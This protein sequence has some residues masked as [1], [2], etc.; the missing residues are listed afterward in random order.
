MERPHLE[1]VLL[2]NPERGPLNPCDLFAKV[3]EAVRNTQTWLS[4]LL[5]ERASRIEQQ[6]FQVPLKQIRRHVSGDDVFV[7]L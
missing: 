4:A 3:L 5:L 1:G 6:G 7:L 2:K